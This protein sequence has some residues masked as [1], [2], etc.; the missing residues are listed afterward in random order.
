MK[1]RLFQIEARA[2]YLRH[3]RHLK[4]HGIHSP[5]IFRWLTCILYEHKPFYAYQSLQQIRKQLKNDK[6]T[7][8][9]NGYGTANQR[10]TTIKSIAKSACSRRKYA[11]L[12]FRIV[13]SIDAQNIVELGTNL[14][15]TTLHLAMPNDKAKVTTFEGE[16]E[17]IKFSKNLFASK[18]MQNI[19]LVEGN[20]NDTL[21]LFLEKTKPLDFVFF[22]ANHA[23]KPTIKYFEMCLKH[24]HSQSIF[25]FD[26]IHHSPEME[27]AW[28]EIQSNPKIR[29]TVDLFQMGIT[30]FN[31]DLQ[32][33]DYIVLF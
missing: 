4:G 17:L 16:C 28:K 27:K 9:L 6:S 31:N 2:H 21:P 19:T 7:I 1:N 23:Y 29:V 20:I 26:D 32:K 13:N 25:V 11:E 12:L 18:N 24:A 22:D 5:Y 33:Q 8:R 15:L 3:A 30:F 10:I 14:G